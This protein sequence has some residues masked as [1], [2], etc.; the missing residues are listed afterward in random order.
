MRVKQFGFRPRQSTTLLLACLVETINRNFDERR[1]TGAVFLDVVKAFD[2]IRVKGLL[3][4]LKVSN[5][6]FLL[7]KATLSYIY[8]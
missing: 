8:C 4:R 6:S 5:F 3:Y 1:L 2:I 7:V